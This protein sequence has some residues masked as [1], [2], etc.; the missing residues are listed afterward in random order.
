MRKGVNPEK[1]KGE[2]NTRSM[3]RIIVVFFIPNIFDD[4]YKE[5]LNVLDACLESITNTIN[6]ETTSI[7]L[8]N[9]NS[10]TDVNS[11]INKYLDK[12]QI[13]K[14]VRYSEN[15]GK[16]YAVMN[17]IR[18]IYEPFVTVS[19]ADVLFIKGWE[20]AI[21]NVYRNFERSGVVAPLPCP[22]LAFN[23]N[24]TA[25]FDT[26]L[27][28]KIKKDKIVSD[29]DCDI[30]LEG[31]G[32][33]SLL[34]RNNRSFNWRTHQY[35]LKRNNEVAILGAGHFVATYRTALINKSNSFPVFKFFNGY[36]DKFIDNK[37]DKKGYYRLSLHKTFAYHIGNRLDKNV[38]TFK[39]LEGEY[40]EIE[41]FKELQ[42]SL[43]KRFTPFYLRSLVFR[44]IKK[45]AKL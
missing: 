15:K 14:Y 34:N 44:I 26:I 42:I 33:D 18:G 29:K 35:Y 30:Y 23:H 10:V 22:N 32:N 45:I 28:L 16:V 8:I 17:E 19:D 2:K 40:V 13:D 25:F 37:A 41:D 9:N 6:F 7:T 11:V 20:K 5:S 12:G 36:E 43:K 27:S 4:Y 21:F 24:N 31:L 39:E 1:F 38:T 3:H